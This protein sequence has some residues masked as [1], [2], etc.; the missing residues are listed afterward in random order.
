MRHAVKG[1]KL[2]RTTSHREAMFRNQLQSLVDKERIVTTLPKAKE[3]RPLAEKVITRGKHGSVYDRRWVL[4]WVLSR[5]LVK[6]VFD[7]IAPRFSSRPGGYLR[8]VK[9][10][11]RQGDGAEMAVLELVER[12]EAAA[13]KDTKDAKDAKD[14]KEAKPKKEAA[15]K[16]KPVKEAKSKATPESKK[17]STKQAGRS[18]RSVPQKTG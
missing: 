14:K 2:G 7:E 18:Q 4:R 15:K 1:R 11:P 13:S 16:E 5:D 6:K 10:G 17:T 12:S 3:L 8:I 9:L